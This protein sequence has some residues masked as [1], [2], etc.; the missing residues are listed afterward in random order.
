[1]KK[2][3]GVLLII[4]LGCTPADYVEQP[5]LVINSELL[6]VVLGTAQDAGY[7]QAGCEKE[8]CKPVYE[9]KEPPRQVVSL[10]LVDRRENKVWLLEATPDFK[11]QLHTL[12]SY[13]PDPDTSSFG[14]VLITHAHIGH[15]SGL[16]QLGHEA[17]GASN[18]PVYAMP[19]MKA[20]LT[21]NG[22]WSQLVSMKN[23]NLI[24][25]QAD[26]S[27]ALSP[28]LSVTP[29]LV[30]HRDEYSE[31]VGFIIQ[32]AR[33]T[34]LFVPD[35]DKWSGWNRNLVDE[36]AKTDLAFVDATFYS[37]DE[38]PNRNMSEILHPFVPETM[39]L[40]AGQP[41]TEK[42][43]II[44]IHFNHT[45]LLMLDGPEADSVRDAGYRLAREGQ[46]Y[47]LD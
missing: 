31:T 32:T 36:V 6:L 21:A 5:N 30:P 25:L 45:N 28:R 40:M 39:A 29:V 42:H 13:L 47:R 44:F 1:M 12:M 10:G 27:A 38:L 19:K 34:V 4:V 33:K 41:A 17:M 9:G 14:G 15:Y 7:P 26:S 20:Y 2:A 23:I 18:I 8:C 3:L 11:W 37:T 16:M 43:K 24:P 46:I 35:I 22:P